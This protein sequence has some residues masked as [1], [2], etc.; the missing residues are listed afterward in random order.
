MAEPEAI[1]WLPYQDTERPPDLA[2]CRFTLR[3]DGRIVVWAEDYAAAGQVYR[4]LVGQA[5]QEK[6]P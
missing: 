4:W 3:P 6:G 2:R 5:L 1:N